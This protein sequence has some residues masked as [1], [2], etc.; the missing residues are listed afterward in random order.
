MKK[1]NKKVIAKGLAFGITIGAA[2]TIKA[3]ATSDI[4]DNYFAK[5]QIE[6]F[7]KEGIINGYPDK[8]FRPNDKITRAEFVRIVNKA[9]GFNKVG[10]KTLKDVKEGAW[11][12][13][14]VKIALEKGYIN[15]YEDNTFRPNENITREQMA[16]ILGTILNIT[17]DGKTNF[18]DDTNIAPWAKRYIDGLVDKGL[19]S[20]YPDKMFKPKNNST[21]G[22][23]VAAIHSASNNKENSNKPE[24]NNPTNSPVM[25]PSIPNKPDN[26]NE[27]SPTEKPNKPIENHP[28]DENI[29]VENPTQS[30]L[31]KA[32]ETENSIEIKGDL[33]NINV[34][35]DKEVIIKENATINEGVVI[36]GTLTVKGNL[37]LNS[38]LSIEN[39]AILNLESKQRVS[40]DKIDGSGSIIVG[41]GT[42][43]TN[44]LLSIKTDIKNINSNSKILIN[45]ISLIGDILNIDGE[46]NF[47]KSGFEKFNKHLLLVDG[48]LTINKEFTQAVIKSTNGANLTLKD[49]AI[50]FENGNSK[51]Y[52]KGH[53]G[54]TDDGNWEKGELP[55]FVIPDEDQ[56][57]ISEE[58]INNVSNLISNIG[59]VK[60][61][62]DSEEF[63]LVYENVLNVQ[64]QFNLLTKKEQE[65]VKNHNVLQQALDDVNRVNTNINKL[66]NAVANIPNI[67]DE[68]SKEDLDNA[69]K[70]VNIAIQIYNDLDEDSKRAVSKV[71]LTTIKTSQENIDR[72]QNAIKYKDDKD[73]L[74]VEELINQLPDLENKTVDDYKTERD[75]EQLKQDEQKIKSVLNSYNSLD[76]KKQPSVSNH[77]LLSRAINKI[78]SLKARI[79]EREISSIDF[80]QLSN[81]KDKVLA[82]KDAY[83]KLD[84]ETKQFIDIK[85]YNNLMRAIGMLHDE[86]LIK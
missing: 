52:L 72:L 8:T 31:N 49:K 15:G 57:L 62:K 28:I 77:D 23:A 79:M 51:E 1:F 26:D 27:N 14:D 56:N 70:Y 21:R 29:V 71:D 59:D 19:I 30:D 64:R 5:T 45:N 75:Y 81:E 33:S 84:K 7:I 20:G 50:L 78:T 11:Y 60:S 47:D 69:Q 67:Y 34:P 32:F 13:N 73:V 35:S 54:A 43:K 38:D 42:L 61:F 16:K 4:S 58:R 40:T 3:S 86:G 18:L 36:N 6:E 66:Y 48:N 2:D 10:T 44:S 55:V 83:D 9:F 12:E 80:K 76:S 39:G 63:K 24:I 82:L 46:L 74:S 22:E 85:Y 53:F 41:K 25:N 17:G 37:T 68:M 65:S